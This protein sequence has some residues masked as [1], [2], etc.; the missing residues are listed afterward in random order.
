MADLL[1][2]LLSAADRGQWPLGDE[3]DAWEMLRNW[4]FQEECRLADEAEAET[5]GAATRALQR[6]FLPHDQFVAIRGEM[7]R[8]RVRV[9]K[10]AQSRIRWKYGWKTGRRAGLIRRDVRAF[11][12]SSRPGGYPGS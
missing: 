11:Y 3:A 4:C 5:W 9:R 12:A 7:L 1:S 10:L 2:E 6:K 8:E